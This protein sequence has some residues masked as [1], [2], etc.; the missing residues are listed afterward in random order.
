V[1]R[2][3]ITTAAIVAAVVLL[4]LATLPPPPIVFPL[5]GADPDLERR[6]IR[7]AYHIHTTRSDGAEDKASV[8]AA[9]ARAGL[10]FA[11][12][13]D[14]GDA[15]RS[16]DPPQYLHGVLC[17][18]GV[19]ISTNGG[20]YVALDMPAAPYP[21]AGEASAVVEDVERLGG[22]GIVAH[23]LHP[24][25][26]L[27]WT[28]WRLPIDGIEW[29]NADVEWRNE[30]PLHLSRV[31]FDYFVRPAAA[32]ASVLDR[33]TAAMARWDELS[34][35]RPVTGLGAADAHGSRMGGLEEG[36]RTIA[37]GPGYE[38]SF[39][40]LTNRL[41]LA[42]AL[43]GD[44]V[45]DARR[46]MEAIRAGRTYVVVDGI[47]D[48][49]LLKRGPEGF[50]LASAVPP[51]GEVRSIRS[52][53]RTRLEIDLPAAPGRPPIPWVVSN[54]TGATPKLVQP[55]RPPPATGRLEL[56]SEWRVE[57]DLASS[58]TVSVLDGVVTME[59]RLGPGVPASQFVGAAA[60]LAS[61]DAVTR[62]TVRGRAGQ[63]MRISVQLRFSPNDDRWVKSVY[64]DTAEREITIDGDELRAADQ[65]GER[66]PTGVPRSILFVVDLV[67][68]RPG[69]QG[70]FSIQ[71]IRVGR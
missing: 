38:A 49:V 46:V 69:S 13:T 25:A 67:N 12:F 4:L 20:H 57:K 37:P 31:L 11:I 24:K 43:T 1:K 51:G 34:S 23:P 45:V 5:D 36:K 16:P 55:D 52:G 19:E 61:Q 42:E 60:D 56:G 54:W 47:A 15:T 64:L 59:Y 22:F 21:L 65:S 50:A 62:L 27:S 32:V 26:G 29:L 40:A 68:A 35:L 71:S 70:T 3:G 28:D 8:A 48:S 41:I 7:G 30:S 39:R 18:D 9:A 2:V 10:A 33:P 58:A 66:L 17:L 53:G 44:A 14:H 6:T 63:P